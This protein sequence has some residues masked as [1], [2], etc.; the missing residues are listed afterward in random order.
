MARNKQ[1]TLAGESFPELRLSRRE[2]RRLSRQSSRTPAAEPGTQG[3]KGFLAR[4]A[5]NRGEA[6][7]R[8]G[9]RG[10]RGRGVGRMSWID[11]LPEAQ[12]T[13]VQV[14]GLWPFIAGS[15]SPVVGV[16]LGRHLLNGSMVCADPVFWFLSNLVS[17]PSAFVLGR[18]GLGKSTLIRRMVAMLD[19]W[20]IIPMILS[21][22]KPD[23]SDLILAMNGQVIALGRGRS[24]INPLDFGP[25]MDRLDSI[26]DLNKRREAVDEMRGRRLT[27]VTGLLA[28]VRNSALEPFE[29]SIMSEALRILD[30]DFDGIPVLSDVTELVRSRHPRLAALAQDQGD[31]QRYLNRVEKL[32]DGLTALGE[33]GPFGDIFA[34]PTTEH[35]DVGRPMAFDLS[36]ID[37]ADLQLQAA[38]QS[39]CWSYGSA[40]VSAEKHLAEAGLRERR[41]YF[42][43]M[44]ELW[45]M[46]RASDVMV[47]FLDS[48]TR[49]NRQRGISQAM[50]THTMNDLELASPHLT[51]MAWGFVE[52]S[53]MVFLGGLAE[54]EMGNLNEVFAMSSAE[55]SMITDWSAEGGIN[56]E[57]SQAATP[58][59]RGK[60]L[61][62][63]GKKPGIPFKV[64][65][66]T[67]E[68]AVNDTNRAWAGAAER[69]RQNTVRAVADVAPIDLPSIEETSDVREVLA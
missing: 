36:A 60:F 22:T 19:A 41:H 9:R 38:V 50:I 39:V 6:A 23:Y 31:F 58:P 65:L 2:A 51:K 5:E 32:I 33:N 57:T 34:R 1:H 48:L 46:L 7:N 18:P 13:T 49:L 45:R 25:L 59:G 67:A 64:Q 63:V 66:T 53:A 68:L 3:F 37:E 20:G 54:R 16:P 62:K 43:V 26:D 30:A 44:D 14:C 21:D 29:Q 8:P 24:A 61:L 10:W 17:Q 12:G 40:V 69:L 27:M 11:P 52:R 42:L 15:G 55:R 56:P 4:A 35:I 47:Y 28:L